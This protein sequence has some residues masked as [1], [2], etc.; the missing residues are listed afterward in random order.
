MYNIRTS[1][2][3]E[4]IH[5]KFNESFVSKRQNEDEEVTSL[6]PPK[7]IEKVDIQEEVKNEASN[8]QSRTQGNTLDEDVLAKLPKSYKFVQNHPMDQIIGEPSQDVRTRVSLHQYCN[9]VTFISNVELTCIDLALED[10]Y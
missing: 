4:S 9:N 10:E 3:E 6:D 7:E 5:V 8:S 1:S 2:L